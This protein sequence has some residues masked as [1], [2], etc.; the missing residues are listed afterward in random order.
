MK[1]IFAA[2]LGI[3]FLA[4]LLTTQAS[5]IGE[6]LLSGSGTPVIDG[7][8]DDVW[9][10]VSRQKFKY[11]VDGDLDDGSGLPASCSAYV[12][13]LWDENALYF[14]IELT[15]N[16]FIF[17]GS[18]EFDSDFLQVYIDE[19]DLFD[20]TWQDGQISFKIY[21]FMDGRVEI[22]NGELDEGTQI[23]VSEKNDNGRIVEIRYVP[24]LL[25]PGKDLKVLADFRFNDVYKKTGGE[26]G[27][28]YGLTWSDELNEGNLDSSN[29]SYLTPGASASD[30]FSAPEEAAQS[31][32]GNL[33]DF[34]KFENG[35]EG[36]GG[37]GPENLWDGDVTTKFCTTL[38]PAKSY[39]RLNGEYCITGVIM[40]TANDN[41]QYN[42]RAPD[43]WEIQGSSN[44]RDW[45]SIAEGDETFFREVNYT[46]FALK[47]EP[48]ENAY[49]Y[50]RF[51]NRSTVSGT[52]Q[53]SE[54]L[55]CG[56]KANAP[57]EEIDVMLNPQPVEAKAAEDIVYLPIVYADN[58]SDGITEAIAVPAAPQENESGISSDAVSAIVVAGAA[59]V[60][61]ALCAVIVVLQSHRSKK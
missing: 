49:R 12:S 38:F 24:T 13:S 7:V 15:D 14:L 59:L 33:I 40:A 28:A 26:N 4:S 3:L 58:S 54:L 19:A 50:I 17:E 45:E 41:A 16:D 43:D 21:P 20:K 27:L 61:A 30:G 5:A 2:V 36:N 9:K 35:T 53:V 52:M 22:V 60:L 29:W 48:T 39:A 1:K 37:E 55:V 47:V 56:V 42:G 25:E 23:A 10:T 51:Y 34:Y 32:G 11:V 6:T 8:I 31:I 46:Y 44:G 18:G 57:Q